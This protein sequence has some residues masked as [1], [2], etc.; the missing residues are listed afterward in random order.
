MSQCFL[1]LT[2]SDSDP[3]DITMTLQL[4]EGKRNTKLYDMSLSFSTSYG[5]HLTSINP[6]WLYKQSYIRLTGFGF[7]ASC[8]CVFGASANITTPA[9]YLSDS[10][11]LCFV[12]SLHFVGTEV[13][14]GQVSQVAL[15]CD[16]Y[17]VTDAQIFFL[18]DIYTVRSELY[19]DEDSSELIVEG[20]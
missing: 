7:T 20:D 15:K 10:E 9:E 5:P 3:T 13:I 6:T 11:A 18:K 8:E 2:Y 19:I 16:G 14:G 1:D 4:W 17:E 12:D